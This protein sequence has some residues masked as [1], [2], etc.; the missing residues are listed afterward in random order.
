M[1][2]KS[3]GGKGGD[4]RQEYDFRELLKGGVQGKYASRFRKGTNLVLL[5]RDV[6]EAFPSDE[7]VNEALRLVIQLKKLPRTDKVTAPQ[8]LDPK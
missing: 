4:L 6:A 2:K 8:D 7:S 1:K 3:K 5:D